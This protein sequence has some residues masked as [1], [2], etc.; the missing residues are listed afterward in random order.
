MNRRRRIL[1]AFAA[2]MVFFWLALVSTGAGHGSYWGVV[3]FYPAQ[4][5]AWAVLLTDAGKA[6]SEN[7]QLVVLAGMCLPWFPLIVTLFTSPKRG[8][9]KLG[10]VLLFLHGLAAA[11]LL[12]LG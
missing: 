10:L 11:G 4:F 7:V 2:G 1:A 9:R 12:I 6:W 3:L 8:V 5:L